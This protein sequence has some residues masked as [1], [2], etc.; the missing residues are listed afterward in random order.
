[1]KWIQNNFARVEDCER[2]CLK[3][4]K[5]GTMGQLET[6][7]TTTTTRIVAS[8]SRRIVEGI[9]LPATIIEIDKASS[10]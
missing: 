5:P 2:A 1:M 9:T 3:K 7:T 6:T 8:S 10:R 4:E